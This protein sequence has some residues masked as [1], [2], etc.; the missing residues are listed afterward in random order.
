MRARLAARRLNWRAMPISHHG[1]PGLSRSRGTVGPDSAPPRGPV[2]VVCRLRGTA[3][4][5]RLAQRAAEATGAPVAPPHRALELVAADRPAQ[6]DDR[7]YDLD[8]AVERLLGHGD[9]AALA[10][11]GAQHARRAEGAPGPGAEAAQAVALVLTAA[12]GAPVDALGLHRAQ[13]LGDLLERCP[14]G[15]DTEEQLGDAAECHGRRADEEAG[16]D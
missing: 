3:L 11:C 9:G 2:G 13:R 6:G 15:G 12:L 1:R 8:L 16:G 5:H 4:A 7:H 14:L 10:A